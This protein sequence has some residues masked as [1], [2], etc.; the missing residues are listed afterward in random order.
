M[1][2]LVNVGFAELPDGPVKSDARLL[3]RSRQAAMA[4]VPTM[5][6]FADRPVDGWKAYA[7][8]VRRYPREALFQ[9]RVIS[10][11]ARTLL[12]ARWFK[13]L[14]SLRRGSAPRRESA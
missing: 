11:A 7:Y 4:G 3:R 9:R 6:I 10:L 12:G 2:R 5:Q 14:Q 1:V 13:R 8:A